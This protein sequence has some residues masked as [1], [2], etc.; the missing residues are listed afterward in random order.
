MNSSSGCSDNEPKRGP[1]PRSVLNRIAALLG[2]PLNFS[3]WPRDDVPCLVGPRFLTYAGVKTRAIRAIMSDW[4][5]RECSPS[6]RIV[7]QCKTPLCCQ[8]HHFRFQQTVSKRGYEPIPEHL[9][10]ASRI[11]AI[12]SMSMPGQQDMREDEIRDC[13]DMILD[14][15]DGRT[16]V[17][18]DLLE[19]LGSY[20]EADI[21]TEAK[22]RIEKDNL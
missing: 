2:Q 12:L 8:P 4:L 11:A 21:I 13:M 20:Y 9:S 6:W 22:L 7:Q 10:G 5:G 18:D 1:R 15:K 3:D 16:A 17:I 19:R 14:L